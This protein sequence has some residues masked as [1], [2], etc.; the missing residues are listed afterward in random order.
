L[1]IDFLQDGRLILAD[2][3]EGRL[4]RQE[5]NGSLA[6]HAD[7]SSAG[8]PP[9]NE[10]VVDR[11]DNAYVNNIGFVFPGGDP[12]PGFVA[13]ASADGT[14]RRVADDLWFPNGMVLTGDGSILLVAES[15]AHQLTAFDITTDG[16]LSNRRV[17][18][19]LGE[20]TPDGICLDAA[21]A[22]WYADVPH[23]CCVRVE[24]GG[25]VLQTV[26][27]DRGCFSC[28]LGGPDGR[29]L[30]L[31]VMPWSGA[32]GMQQTERTSQV[33]GVRVD[34]PGVLQ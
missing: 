19:H 30:F 16:G 24:E 26:E 15:Y 10:V 17:W 31:V 34:V 14:V 33:L 8:P 3:A 23:Q 11:R 28:A 7:L 32:G 6:V 4:L 12:A 1:C 25:R 27:I 29:T 22:V 9:W 5:R 2:S 13:M 21:G 18:A 20:G